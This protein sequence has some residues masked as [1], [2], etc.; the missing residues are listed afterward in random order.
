MRGVPQQ[1][2]HTLRTVPPPSRGLNT[3]G[4]LASMP[5]TD[6][7][8]MDNLIASEFGLTVR[9]GYR[10]YATNIGGDAT[11]V[12]RTV[13]AFNGASANAMINPLT[14]SELWAATDNGIYLIEGGG[15]LAALAPAIALSGSTYAGSFSWVNF[16][17][18]GGGQY[19]V[20]CSETDGAYLYDGVSWMKMVAGGAGAGHI[21][22]ADPTTFAQVCAWKRL[23]VF[24]ERAT[25]KAWFLPIGA[26]GGAVTVFD[27]GPQLEH[28]GAVLGLANWTQDDGGGMDDRLV[29]LGSSGDL[30]IYQGTDPTD[31][32]KFSNAGTWYIGQPPVGRRCFTTSGGNVY[33]LT[34]FGV[35]PVNQIVQGGLDNILTSDTD[36]LVQLRKLQD[37]LNTDFQTLLNTPGWELLAVPQLALILIA[38]P[39]VVSNEFI[40]YAFQQHSMAWSR[41]IDIPGH[42]FMR[43]LNE[44]YAGTADGRVL[45]VLDGSTDDMKLD[46]SGAREIRSRLTPAFNYF[47]DPSVL[48]HALMIRVS[49]LARMPPAYNVAMNV[50]FE[51]NPI[52]STAPAGE[53]A[54]SLWDQSFWDVDLWA[55]G[56]TASAEWRTVGALGYALSPSLFISSDVATTV[57]SIEYMMKQGGPW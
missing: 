31:A 10:E 22:G 48:K 12:V 24:V 44:V 56:R 29:I 39:S 46:G 43:R 53:T 37:A 27:F 5:P 21:T 52:N 18:S 51:V 3:T 13:M 1:R 16:T 17:P 57:T 33:V 54:G 4:D 50:N 38:R 15:D 20:A 23:L 14:D 40:Q 32:A 19:L 2:L 25:G 9:G 7:V 8:E 6:A 35:I 34:Q 42:T 45:R 11:H 41:L 47:D 49:F 30:V 28:G 55:G 26:V 36:L